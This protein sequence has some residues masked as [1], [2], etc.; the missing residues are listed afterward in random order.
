VAAYEK[1][2]DVFTNFNTVS[3]PI[4][5]ERALYLLD[6][7]LP[8]DVERIDYLVTWRSGATV[9]WLSVHKLSSAPYDG[10]DSN[11]VI[12]LARKQQTRSAHGG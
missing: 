2:A 3:G 4:G 5:N 7:G 8:I 9:G 11:L 1:A 6:L 12:K 10:L